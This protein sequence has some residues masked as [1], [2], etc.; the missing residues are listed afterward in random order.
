MKYYP[1]YLNLKDK[2]AV[3]VGG[4]GVAERK[5]LTLVKA[6]ASVK[7]ISPSITRRLKKLV[8]NGKIIHIK[9]N[10][11]RGD[12]KGAFVVIAGTSSVEINTG[13]ARDAGHLIN[14]IDTPSEGNF[15]APSIVKRGP[16]TLAISTEGASPAVSKAIRK[17]IEKFYGREFALY[18]KL[19]KS[20][21]RKA[22]KKIADPKKREKLLKTLAAGEIFRALRNKGFGAVSK[23]ISALL[24][25]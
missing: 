5:A 13:I 4:G 20:V 6:G 25:K 8:E 21:R 3:V 22:M 19:M 18:L 1:V 16:L 17:E 14:V 2:K 12:L 15:I 23:K 11:K 24:D 10:Y 9:R 7:I